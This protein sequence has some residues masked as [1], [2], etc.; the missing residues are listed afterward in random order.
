MPYAF[1]AD[2]TTIEIAKSVSVPPATPT[3]TEWNDLQDDVDVLKLHK[4]VDHPD[5]DDTGLADGD[6]LVYNSTTLKFEAGT[7]TGGLVT[8]SEDT[9]PV[10]T[11]PVTELQA[12]EGLLATEVSPGVGRISMTFAGTGTSSSSSRSDHTHRAPTIDFFNFG[13]TGAT[14]D[15]VAPSSRTVLNQSI[16]TFN[17]GDPVTVEVDTFIH[18]Q[19]IGA[20]GVGIITITIDG[21]AYASS[22]LAGVQNL[23]WEQGVN[24]THPWQH[25]R[26]ITRALIGDPSTR[27]ISVAVQCTSGTMQIISGWMKIR[28]TYVS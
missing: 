6:Q 14:P 9:T 25:S 10:N 1:Q 17:V 18:A 16:G 8:F 5:V 7:T 24:T 12:W 27:A 22:I 2:I 15:L 3:L 28:R 11:A 4:L 23:V 13:S 21:N 19:G 26:V 20:P